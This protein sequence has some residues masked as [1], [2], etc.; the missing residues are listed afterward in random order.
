L[1]VTSLLAG[2]SAGADS[3]YDT[4]WPTI[5]YTDAVF[6]RTANRWIS[7][8]EVA[9]LNVTAFTSKKKVDR[10]PGRLVARRI[11]DLNP[12]ATTGRPRCSTPGASTR[13]SPPATRP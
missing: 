12:R 1:K 8:A 11:P 3:I 2:M 10:V 7:R 13:S 5:Q 4:A 6:D 9:E